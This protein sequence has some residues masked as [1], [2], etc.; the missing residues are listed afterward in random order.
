MPAR[1]FGAWVR[2]WGVRGPA[3][4][5]DAELPISL[6]RLPESVAMP[7]S[8]KQPVR[9]PKPAAQ[10]E[11]APDAELQAAARVAAQ[12]TRAPIAFVALIGADAGTR[13]AYPACVGIDARQLDPGFALRTHQT[14]AAP[15]LVIESLNADAQF[16]VLP[17]VAGAP[18]LRVY[19]GVPI[20]D[21]QG[22]PLGTLG[23]LDVVQRGLDAGQRAGLRDLASVVRLALQA[24][25]QIGELAREAAHDAL[26]GLANRKPF[27]QAL[28][29]ELHHAMRTGEPFALLRLSLDGICD[30]RNGFGPADANA[31]LREVSARMATR[32]RLGDVLARLGGD[33]FGIVMRHGAA[34][35]A[36]VLA[37]R[38]VDAVRQ[39]LTLADGEAVGVRVC[40][41][42]AAY[43]DEVES[44]AA[45]QAQAE[46]ALDAARREY[47]HRW[48]F[49]GR[50]FDGAALRLVETAAAVPDP[51]PSTSG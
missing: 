45:L 44:A 34:T 16:G 42:I 50:K 12:L 43:T 2:A 6:Y 25:R 49:F 27:E 17:L 35:A 9:A 13:L 26:T 30:I 22:T 38:I 36:E 39:P 8:Q 40:I 51:D 19:A 33:E 14:R 1:G 47:D 48:S 15:P 23:V 21:A 20:L 7:R 37:A 29:V 31:A 4:E 18:W 3:L 11:V 5:F 28:Q 41:G 46:L 24:R 10:L 32:V